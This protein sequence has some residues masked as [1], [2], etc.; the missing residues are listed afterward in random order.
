MEKVLERVGKPRNYGSTAKDL[1]EA[2]RQVEIRLGQK[3]EARQV[4][5]KRKK[6]EEEQQAQQQEQR[7]R[8]HTTP[9]L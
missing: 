6:E 3:E 4:E 8:R 7:V 1:E 2:R 5:A 9:G